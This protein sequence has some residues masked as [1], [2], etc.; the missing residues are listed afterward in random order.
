MTLANSP[1]RLRVYYSDT[2]ELPLPDGHRF[3]IEKYRLLRERLE[4][5]SF[6]N[7]LEFCLPNA[8][9]D[10]Q[11]LLVHTADYLDKLN[12]GTLSRIEERRIG[13]PWSLRMVERSRHSTGA[14]IGAAR[15]ALEDRA[16]VHLA[17]GTHH[18]FPD[19]GQGFCVFNDVAVAIRLLQAEK[20]IRRAVVID[21]DVHQGNGTAAIFADDPAVFTFSMHGERNFPFTK[22]NGDLDIA[23]PDG[24]ADETYID[25]LRDALECGLPLADADAVFYLAGADPYEHDRFGKLKLTK[26]GLAKRDQLVIESCNRHRLPLTVVMAGGYAKTVEDVAE[27]NATTISTLLA[28]DRRPVN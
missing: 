1:A 18:A 12:Y 13:F 10:D 3:P 7:Q 21:L 16:A 19:H 9:T 25:A 24:T 26:A 11:L 20:L 22:C 28:A 14:T 8:A 4:K 6:R 2:F 5:A 15:A 27:I 17:G 23:L